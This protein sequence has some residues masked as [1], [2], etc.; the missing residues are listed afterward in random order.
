MVQEFNNNDCST[1]VRLVTFLLTMPHEMVVRSISGG[2]LCCISVATD[3]ACG[4]DLS[5]KIASQTGICECKLQL[6]AGNCIVQSDTS[7]ARILE[8]MQPNNV[9]YACQRR[10]LASGSNAADLIADGFCFRCMKLSGVQADEILALPR[11]IDVRAL[12][13]AGYS[14][15]ELVRAR[16]LLP[17]LVCHPPATNRTLFDSQLQLAG[18]SAGE[19]REAGYDARELSYVNFLYPVY[20]ADELTCQEKE[21][22]QTGAFFTATQM[23]EANYTER[24][25][26][27]ARFTNED[28]REAGYVSEEQQ[29]D[30]CPTVMCSQTVD[31]K[32]RKHQCCK[33]RPIVGQMGGKTVSCKDFK[34]PGVSCRHSKQPE[35]LDI[36]NQRR[37]RAR[38]HFHM[39]KRVTK[40]NASNWHEETVAG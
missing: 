21:W 26:Q 18:Y 4:R 34:Q 31:V 29:C 38:A 36:K 5:F 11:D 16:A 24:E 25:L 39:G 22:L 10:M 40:L 32:Y 1:T 23:R 17:H 12:K 30:V 20:T 7:V 6:A 33:S 28:L 8:L 27:S 9:I 3:T 35:V 13:A 14:L 19:F 2:I 37:V 15:T